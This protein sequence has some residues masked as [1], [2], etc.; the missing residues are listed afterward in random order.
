[1]YNTLSLRKFSFNFEIGFFYTM[2][3][4]RSEILVNLEL[5]GGVIKA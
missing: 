5:V 1:M 3:P 2:R 4:Q